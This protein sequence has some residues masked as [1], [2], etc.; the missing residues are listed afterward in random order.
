MT[1]STLPESLFKQPRVDKGTR[2]ERKLRQRLA[3]RAEHNRINEL[4]PRTINGNKL[5]LRLRRQIVTDVL[6]EAQRRA[7]QW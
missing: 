7:K 6:V 1:P 5:G 2:K 3:R 4:L